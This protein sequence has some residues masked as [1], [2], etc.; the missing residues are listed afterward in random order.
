MHHLVLEPC[1]CIKES[2]VYSYGYMYKYLL[3]ARQY[4]KPVAEIWPLY[5]NTKW[6]LSDRVLGEAGEKNK[7]NCFI[8]LPGKGGHALKTTRPD[9]ERV[10]RNFIV[11][12]QRGGCDQLMDILLIGWW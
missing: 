10:V 1:H 9:L 3:C 5:T 6:N 11:I 12:V 2:K 4:A 8:A 7:N